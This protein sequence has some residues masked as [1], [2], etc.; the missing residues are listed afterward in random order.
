MLHMRKDNAKK[1]PHLMSF[2]TVR[3]PNTSDQRRVQHRAL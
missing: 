2:V 1:K 3:A